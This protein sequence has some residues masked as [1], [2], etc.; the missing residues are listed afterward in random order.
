MYWQLEVRA[1]G[2]PKSLNPEGTPLFHPHPPPSFFLFSSP[3]KI[4]NPWNQNRI[5]FLLKI[6]EQKNQSYINMIFKILRWQIPIFET[7]NYKN[8]FGYMICFILF[9]LFYWLDLNSLTKTQSSHD[10]FSSSVFKLRH[11]LLILES[12]YE[13]T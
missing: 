3:L 2:N 6:D 10:H 8:G 11:L 4:H 5:P 7:Y 9:K 13:N 12:C 1:R